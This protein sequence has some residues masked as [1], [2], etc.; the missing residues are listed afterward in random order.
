VFLDKMPEHAVV[1]WAVAN[2]K[3]K[4]G[5][6]LASVAN[7]CLRALCREGDALRK[8]DYYQAAHLDEQ[9]RQ[10]LY[11][12]LPLWIV[13][14]WH[15]GYGPDTAALFMA[16]SAAR[17]AAG[18]RVNRLRP[19]WANLAQQL[20]TAGAQRV[21]S[22]CFAVAPEQRAQLERRCALA[23]MLAAGRISR[24][25]AA[26]QL[27]LLAL[28]P[29][30]WPDPLWDACAG[31]GGK[32]CALLE[33]GKDVR[34]AADTH[35]PRL[36]RIRDE[37]AR[38]GLLAPCVVQASVMH[39][40][41]AFKPGTIVLDVPCSSLGV[42]AARPDIR[43]HRT[44]EHVQSLIRRQAAMLEAAY[45]ELP[46]GGHI[47]YMTCTQNPAENEAQI[48]ALLDRNPAGVLMQEWNAPAESM[49]LEGMYAALLMKR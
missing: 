7:A 21:A 19:D 4:H 36:R 34:M 46:V 15:A 37:C 14:L 24:Q 27:A 10:A 30:T 38:L 17:P 35:L 32:S 8:Y 40:P 22:A 39:P 6:T 48:R 1:D 28:R 20:A 26:S 11:Y 44:A 25:G 3:R 45:A 16:R 9:A 29:E 33:L 5:N 47:A 42:L 43:R 23:D 12:S 13:K 31:Q 49:L 18:L 41:M 2:I